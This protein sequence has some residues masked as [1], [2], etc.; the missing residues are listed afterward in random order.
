MNMHA[1]DL[2]PPPP[3]AHRATFRQRQASSFGRL[4]FRDELHKQPLSKVRTL[5]R[6]LGL[7]HLVVVNSDNTVYGIVTRKELAE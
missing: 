5:F 6:S 1:S 2:R 4:V 7:R 3:P